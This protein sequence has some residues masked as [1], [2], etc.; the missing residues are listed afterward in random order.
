MEQP[1]FK[2]QIREAAVGELNFTRLLDM[3]ID[4]FIEDAFVA[5]AIERRRRDADQIVTIEPTIRSGPV[6]FMFSRASVAPEIVE[7][8]DQALVAMQ[9][10]GKH[11]QLLEQ[12][13]E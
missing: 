5:A 12:Y 11:R 7:R 8:F 10:S 6:T 3:Q 4:G 2:P 13:L 9:K 1:E